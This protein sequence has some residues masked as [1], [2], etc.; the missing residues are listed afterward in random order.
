MK[1]SRCRT[2]TVWIT[3]LSAVVVSQLGRTSLAQ[4]GANGARS[5]VPYYVE[6]SRFQYNR[7]QSRSGVGGSAIP[8]TNFTIQVPRSRAFLYSPGVYYSNG[9]YGAGRYPVVPQY[10][11]TPRYYYR[12]QRGVSVH[13]GPFIPARRF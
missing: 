13:L 1:R 3:C 10:Y 6:P 2:I 9:F 5:S 4:V 11:N 7:P 8:T 12:P